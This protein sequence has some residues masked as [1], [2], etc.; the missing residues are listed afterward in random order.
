MNYR[1]TTS[2]LTSALILGIDGCAKPSTADAP[3]DRTAT[4]VTAST[5]D[6]AA[7][8]AK[9]PITKFKAYTRRFAGET[10]LIPA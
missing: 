8:P 3:T 10:L 1:L 5:A 7:L 6:A 9:P 2:V 4:A